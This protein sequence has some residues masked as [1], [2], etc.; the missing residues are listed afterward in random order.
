ME[1]QLAKLVS[2]DDRI[3]ARAQVATGPRFEWCVLVSILAV[4]NFIIVNLHNFG[5]VS[6]AWWTILNYGTP[7][8]LLAIIVLA[9]SI[10]PAFLVVTEQQVIC[11]RIWLRVFERPTRVL[12]VGPVTSFTIAEQTSLLPGVRVARCHGP[13][14]KARGIRFTGIA[15]WREDLGAVVAAL[16][17]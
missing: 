1:P 15:R 6:A 17:G 7:A 5:A 2:S 8:I 12:F 16:T 10:R 14:I 9:I 13:D 4:L 11:L 3:V